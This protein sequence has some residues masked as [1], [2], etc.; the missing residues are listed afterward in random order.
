MLPVHFVSPKKYRVW[1]TDDYPRAKIHSA[2]S[3]GWWG[4]SRIH[5]Y[6][7]FRANSGSP[8]VMVHM[9]VYG[10]ALAP[11]ILGQHFRLTPRWTERTKPVLDTMLP[12]V[13]DIKIISMLY[14]VALDREASSSSFRFN[15]IRYQSIV[16]FGWA[17]IRWP[18]CKCQTHR[19]DWKPTEMMASSITRVSL[20]N[21]RSHA[22][23]ECGVGMR[24]WN[25]GLKYRSELYFNIQCEMNKWR[26]THDSSLSFSKFYFYYFCFAFPVDME[27]QSQQTPS[28]WWV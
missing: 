20:P 23:V 25:A 10:K 17:S 5:A 28:Y 18:K 16:T 21:I 3:Y 8:S 27:N 6:R 12:H 15:P 14:L 1:H 22:R 7:R 4:S 24:K 26:C 9:F 2:V 13:S 19:N 11:P